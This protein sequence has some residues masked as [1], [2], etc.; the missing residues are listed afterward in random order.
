MNEGQKDLQ[1]IGDIYI[2]S[3]CQYDFPFTDHRNSNLT[4]GGLNH[5]NTRSFR[6]IY[7]SSHNELF[8]SLPVCRLSFST[9]PSRAIEYPGL[10]IAQNLDI[11]NTEDEDATDFDNGR[12]F[13]GIIHGGK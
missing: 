6:F 7:F 12:F 5:D 8:H 2:D 10:N 3:G 13:H 4:P 11:L 1:N 9:Q